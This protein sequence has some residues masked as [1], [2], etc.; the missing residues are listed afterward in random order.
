MYSPEVGYTLVSIGRLDENGFTATFGDGK[1]II[2]GPDDECVG[3]ILKNKR[4]LYKVEHELNI[5]EVNAVEE[6]T[7][8]LFGT[9]VPYNCE[10]TY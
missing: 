5:E 9:H 6:S 10:E 1:C 2:H 7:P 4:G 8:P 3:R